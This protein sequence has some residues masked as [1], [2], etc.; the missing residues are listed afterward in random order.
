MENDA[1]SRG[2]RVR[3]DCDQMRSM[4]YYVLCTMYGT[5]PLPSL[6]KSYG[7]TTEMTAHIFLF[8][9]QP[10]HDKGWRQKAKAGLFRTKIRIW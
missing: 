10:A 4:E 9:S 7:A 3:Y 8:N 6:C 2:A 5:A 1:I